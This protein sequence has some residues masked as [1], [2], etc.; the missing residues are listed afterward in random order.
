MSAVVVVFDDGTFGGKKTSAIA[1]P[2]LGAH[3][4]DLGDA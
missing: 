2:E 4:L 3:R 1:T